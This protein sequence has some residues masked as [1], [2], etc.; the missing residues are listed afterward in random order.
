MPTRMWQGRVVRNMVAWTASC[1]IFC[2]RAGRDT[3][4]TR[5]ARAFCMAAVESMRDSR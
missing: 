2:A 5:R 3:V 1:R 4:D